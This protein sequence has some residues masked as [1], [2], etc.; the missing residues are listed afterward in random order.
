MHVHEHS[1]IQGQALNHSLILSVKERTLNLKKMKKILLSAIAIITVSLFSTNICIA[2]SEISATNSVTEVT[3]TRTVEVWKISGNVRVKDKGV[4]DID[5][6]KI[7]VRGNSYSVQ[8]N[9]DYGKDNRRGQYR[10][11]AGGV[12]YFNL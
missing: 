7:T 6:Q 8:E 9:P 1:F 2:N 12:Y 11:Y 5:S 4:Y 10:Y 3:D